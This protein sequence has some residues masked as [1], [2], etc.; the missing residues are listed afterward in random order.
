M[1]PFLDQNTCAELRTKSGRDF[2]NNFISQKVLALS[3]NEEITAVF[4]TKQGFISYMSVVLQRE[5]H[6]AVKTS[7]NNFR[8]R[9]NLT[10][11]DMQYR[12]QEK[13]LNEV[14]QLSITHVCPENQLKGK[15][16]GR[17]EGSKAYAL[18]SNFKRFEVTEDVLKIH[19]T[20]PLELTENDKEIIL[21]QAKAVYSTANGINVECVDKVEFVVNTTAY[22]PVGSPPSTN[23][24]PAS[25]PVYTSVERTPEINLPEGV[26]GKV[27]KS[28][29]YEYGKNLYNHWLA[30][31][32]VVEKANT[33]QLQT[34]S[35]MVKDR[36]EQT[37]LQFLSKVASEFGINKMDFTKLNM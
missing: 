33:I 28:F 22:Q 3:H 36:I 14:E 34:S 12:T 32:S 7:G 37:Y 24:L 23:G 16:A 5:L 26:W 1:Q 27:A 17:L 9:V 19:L 18:L 10:S 21:S 2:S 6:D 35:D 31:L 8:L 15:L 29:I 30:G 4:K 25:K 20:K 11:E 13:L